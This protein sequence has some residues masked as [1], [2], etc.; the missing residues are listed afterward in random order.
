MIEMTED[1]LQVIAFFSGLCVLI[2]Q[3]ISYIFGYKAG[4][5]S[6]LEMLNKDKEE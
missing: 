1:S 3:L 5:R 4:Q 6:A 2:I